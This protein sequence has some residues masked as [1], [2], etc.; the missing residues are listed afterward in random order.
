LAERAIGDNRDV[1]L[2][3]VEVPPLS[4]E[5]FESIV[6]D[7]RTYDLV[8][9]ATSV[10]ARLDGRTVW[11]INST[12][13]GGGVAEMLPVI[14][15]Y[16]RGAGIDTR[17]TVIEGDEHF[18]VV[19]KR[20]HHWIHGA[21]GDRAALSEGDIAHYERV[22]ERNGHELSARVRAGDVVILHDPQTAGLI[23]IVAK[24]GAKVVWRCHIGSSTESNRTDDGWSFLRH[25]LNDADAI[26]FS[27]AAYAPSWMPLTNVRIIPPSIDPFAAKNQVLDDDDVRS[28]LR[29]LGI[30]DGAPR[31][32]G[33]FVR[34]DG[35]IGEVTRG[36]TIVRSTAPI[37][38]DTPLVVQVS[39]W[40]PL[41]DMAGVMDAF[42]NATDGSGAHL[43]LVGPAVDA[44]GDDPEGARVLADCTERWQALPSYARDRIMLV[45][46]PMDDVDENAAMVNAI[47]RHAAVVVQKSLAEGFGLTVAEAMWK[48]RAVLASNVGGIP[49][50]IAPGT[51]VLLDDPTDLAAAGAELMR[52]IADHDLRKS[53]GEAAHDQVCWHYVGDQHLI[54]WA[55]LIGE[56]RA[57]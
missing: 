19:T 39:R 50:Q 36:A 23:P 9:A 1:P 5:R 37:S 46:L 16:A 33:R 30:V 7:R 25:Y 14:V 44:V 31:E 29:R 12:A 2:L 4:A 3:D 24:T 10:R 27:R 22:L 53:I 18:F 6:G 48:R 35:T 20:I 32:A 38:L 28:I 15:G 54:R 57:E 55:E 47:Q 45:T 43:A 26:V 8:A 49:D 52:L 42:A 56:L 40:D 21:D 41:K 34:R 51:G 11:N 17:W 13:S